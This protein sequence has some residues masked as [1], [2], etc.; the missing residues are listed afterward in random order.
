[1]PILGVIASS[2]LGFIPNNSYESIATATPSG[3]SSI[4]FTSIPNTYKHLQIRITGRT[5]VANEN[6]GYASL[7][8]NGDTTSGNYY[9]YHFIGATGTGTPNAAAGSTNAIIY[10]GVLAGNNAIANSFGATIIDILEY[11]STNRF[12]T[13]RSNSGMSNNSLN[14][15]MRIASG[16]WFNTAAINSINVSANAKGNNFLAGTTI[17]L[18]GI[19]G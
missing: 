13:V 12:K 10:A 16:F 1:M 14:S 9:F 7:Q 17:A 19:K 4:D 6:D 18:Y 3:V 15:N 8:F 5:S 2:G 11:N